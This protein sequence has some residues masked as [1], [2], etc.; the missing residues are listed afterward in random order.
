M[1]LSGQRMRRERFVGIN[2]GSSE[3]PGE[4]DVAF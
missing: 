1:V 3:L 4:S 2:V